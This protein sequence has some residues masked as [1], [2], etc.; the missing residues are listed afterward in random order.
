MYMRMNFYLPV[1]LFLF[2][3]QRIRI[4]NT[5]ELMIAVQLLVWLGGSVIPVSDITVEPIDTVSSSSDTIEYSFDKTSD[6]S[7][8][9][10][11]PIWVCNR[12]GPD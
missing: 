8:C 7:L 12:V 4:Y 5:V 2:R 9:I 11:S 1:L 10:F 3:D 6:N